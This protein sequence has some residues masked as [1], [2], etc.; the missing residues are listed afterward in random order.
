MTTVAMRKIVHQYLDDAD[1]TALTVIYKM[2]KSYKKGQ[3][4]PESMLTKGQ[5]AELDKTLRDHKAGKLKYHTLNAAKKLVDK[6]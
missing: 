2:L 6:A 4:S 3:E 5:K 1:D